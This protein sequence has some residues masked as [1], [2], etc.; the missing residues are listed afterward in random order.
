MAVNKRLLQGAAAGGLVPSENFKAVTY[1]GNGTTNYIDVGFKPDIVWI[2]RR[3]AGA[4]HALFDSTRGR[5]YILYPDDTSEQGGPIAANRD[6]K[7]FDDNGFTLSTDSYGNVNTI[8]NTYVAWC[9]KANG[10]TTSSNTDGTV[11]STVQANT[12]AGFSIIKY[13]GNG[14]INQSIGHGLNSTPELYITKNLDTYGRVWVVKTTVVDGSLDELLLNTNDAANNIGNT[15]L[16]TSSVIYQYNNTNLGA[17]GQNYIV[18]A[19]HSVDGFSKIGSYTGNGSTEGPIV[20]T[21]FEPAFI[22]IKDASGTDNWAMVDNKRATTNPRQT[23]LRANLYNAEFS[24]TVDSINFYSNGFQIAGGT[25]VSNFLNESGNTFIY[26]A[27]AADPDTEAPTVAK[28]FST[29]AYSGDSSS[30]RSIDGLGFSPSLVWIKNRTVAGWHHLDDIVRGANNTIFSNATNAE[31]SNIAGGYLSAF[32]DDGF[33]LNFGTN[34]SDVN[35]TGEDYVAWAWKADDNEP[36]IFG[37]PAIAVYKFE[38]NANDVTTNYNGTASNVTYSSSGKFNKA[39]SFNGTSGK[40]EIDALDSFFNQKQTFSVSLWFKTTESS[41]NGVLFSDYANTSININATVVGSTGAASIST[42]YSGNTASFSST[43]T[44]LNDG[45]W[46]H[47]VYTSDKVTGKMYI[48]GSLSNTVTLSTSG[49]NGDSNLIP[50][51]GAKYEPQSSVYNGFFNGQ[52]DQVRIYQ[53]A[54]AQEQVDELYAETASDN[55]DLTLG[56]PPK[57]IVSA[58]ANAGFSIVQYEGTGSNTQVPHGLSAAPEM[59]II[60]ST[61]NGGS[62]YTWGVYHTGI[63][64]TKYLELNYNYAA[65]TA[66]TP[67]NDT[68]PT[69]TIFNLGSW[70][71]VNGSGVDYIA[72]CFHSVSGYSK[73]GSYTGTGSSQTITTGF[74]PDWIVTKR[75][76][77]TDN[78]RMYDSVRQN[79]QPFD[80]ILYPNLS[81]AEEDNN[82]FVTG[83]TS[84]GFTLGSGGGSNASG[85]TYI[86]MAFKIN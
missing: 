31:T 27:F 44:G 8:G 49:W 73:F 72:Y 4:S 59:M 61:S 82:T 26:M 15:N 22:I 60:K 55:D 33:E 74:Q 52:I 14:V 45:N 11:T 69:S 76:E 41:N 48:N 46:H 21:G 43:E 56:A 58:N 79:T 19:F 5:E 23:W 51:I 9:W 63:G 39:A 70:S 12:D 78:W 3:D 71:A 40:V 77:T 7:S 18:Y 50:M 28:S 36:T 34:G 81:N 68:A 37:G 17:N 47:F 67:W 85:G 53:G 10:G 25:S 38:D 20:E 32:E 2:K 6:I 13:V 54:I 30:T 86:Y 29:V 42:R 65:A 66:S 1:N 35:K 64:P 83:T 80:E 75:T 62:S 84:T 24:N 57:S 16:P